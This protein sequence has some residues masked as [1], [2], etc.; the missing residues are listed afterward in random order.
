MDKRDINSVKE[1]I[2]EVFSEEGNYTCIE[3]DTDESWED[4][5]HRSLPDLPEDCIEVLKGLVTKNGDESNNATEI[6][7]EEFAYALCDIYDYQ[8]EEWEC[9]N[10]FDS[11]GLDIYILSFVLS[12]GPS[13]DFTYSLNNVY[14]LN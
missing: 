11:P 4:A 6:S 3:R 14:Y 2:E 10:V 13:N 5:L 7:T 12:N 1:I 9:D 8:I